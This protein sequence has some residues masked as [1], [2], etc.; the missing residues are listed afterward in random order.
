VAGEQLAPPALGQIAADA[1]GERQALDQPGDV[2]VR[3]P[4]AQRALA[5]ARGSKAKCGR[6]GW[7]AMVSADRL[8]L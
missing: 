7:S 5:V 2:L 8:A 1:G 4:V 3:Q 6:W